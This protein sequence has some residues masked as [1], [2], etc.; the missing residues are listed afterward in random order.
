MLLQSSL[1]TFGLCVLGDP[2]IIWSY[3]PALLLKCICYLQ[4]WAR[5][6][7]D[8]Q[9][10]AA[11]ETDNGTEAIN[12]LM[13]YRY[14]PRWKNITLSNVTNTC[15]RICSS[16]PLQV[17]YREFHADIP[18]QGLQAFGYTSIPTG[19]TKIHFPTLF[20]LQSN[21]EQT[22]LQWHTWCG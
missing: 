3:S 10:H 7:R 11:V 18:I 15:W 8:D 16:P 12:K 14:L 9:N 19:T 13:K 1:V 2:C 5:A 22:Q 4:W 17:R 6:Y 20:V 21:K